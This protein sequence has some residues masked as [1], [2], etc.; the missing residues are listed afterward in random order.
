MLPVNQAHSLIYPDPTVQ[1][2][3]SGQKVV[4][5]WYAEKDKF[6][7]GQEPAG[8]M[9]TA[10]ER[11]AI[12]TKDNTVAIVN[13][14]SKRNY[15]VLL[16]SYHPLPL[17]QDTSRRWFG[18]QQTSW[19]LGWPLVTPRGTSTQSPSTPQKG[20]GSESSLDRSTLQGGQVQVLREL[21]TKYIYCI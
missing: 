10:G 2:V 16:L 4:D 8:T 21:G 6:T 15:N 19:G 7:F 9:L 14:F 13:Q 12:D 18:V 1:S 11:E 5:E 3:A 20:T 17:P